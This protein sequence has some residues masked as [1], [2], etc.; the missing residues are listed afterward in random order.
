M[1]MVSRLVYRLHSLPTE[2]PS[3]AHAQQSR[4]YLSENFR[5]A[6]YARRKFVQ[7][8]LSSHAIRR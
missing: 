2:L 8:V 1:L 7:S 6:R 5:S 3:H 4:V